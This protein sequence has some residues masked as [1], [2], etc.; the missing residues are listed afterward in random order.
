MTTQNHSENSKRIAKNT[1][2]LYIRMLVLMIVGLYTSRVNLQALGVDDYGISSVVGGLVSMFY[3]VSS[4]FTGSISRF[5][6]IGLGK[7]DKNQLQRVF[8]TSKVIQY[9]LVVI[10]V[11][12]AETVGLW[13]LNNKMVIPS[14]RI[15]AAN[16]VFQ[17]SLLS[18]CLDLL[19]VPYMAAIVAHEKMSAF[20]YISILQ[21]AGK[22]V[23][24]W[25]TLI[26]PI[27]RLIWF[28]GMIVTI[29]IFI[30]IVY[31]VYCKSHFEECSGDFIYD[32]KLF[33]QMTGFAGWNFIGTTAAILRD[34]GGNIVINIFSGPAVNAARGI[35]NQVNNAVFSFADN[36]Q[37][38][39]K[40]QITKNYAS[41]DHD[42]M[43]KLVFQGARL[44]YYILLLLAVPIICNIHYLVQLWLGKVPDHTELFIQLVLIFTLS[45][46]LASTLITLMLATGKIRDFQII[47][48]GLNLLNVPISYLV[49]RLGAMPEAVMMV[50]IF[51]S[52][53][54]EM[55]RLLL[56]RK[57]VHLSVRA[58]LKNVYLNV[59][60]V[61]IAAAVIPMWL[62]YTVQ[63]NLLTFLL[64]CMVS[65]ICTILSILFIGCVREER[66][67]VYS[68]S[69]CIIKNFTSKLHK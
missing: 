32:K 4:T 48:G 24:A 55:A 19:I 51:I 64:N 9:L 45:E 6:T 37:T 33:K 69:R 29:S 5:I 8:S 42:Y 11:I 67:L 27:D 50:A 2:M 34:Y 17:F 47:V 39:L 12:L 10:V 16:W 68:K 28:S 31:L 54:C 21:A 49:L 22:L 35:A 7:G 20:A 23:V 43:F 52:V 53:C 57:M 30:R 56:L 63:E 18:F 59:I 60:I 1:V 3:I 25:T 46:S 36:F 40:P 44:S 66:Q 41:G 26:A 13:F 58:F 38:A 65:L 14:E 61:S 62:H 15:V